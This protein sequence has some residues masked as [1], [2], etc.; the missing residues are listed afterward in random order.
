MD[1]VFSRELRLKNRDVDMFRRLRTSRLF[2]LLQEAAIA[3]TEQLGAGREKTLDR[4]LLWVITLQEARISRLPE[5]GER[6]KL[7]SWPGDMMHVFFPRYSILRGEDGETLLTASA[8]WTLSD[9]ETRKLTFPEETGVTVSGFR[10]GEEPALP[11]APKAL[12]AETT[13]HFTVPRSYTDINGHM[14]N[15]RYFDLLEDTLP[16]DLRDGRLTRIRA[17]YSGEVPEGAELRLTLGRDGRNCTLTG[18]TERRV[19]RLAAD[20]E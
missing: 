17:E 5:Y 10:T 19:F 6:M 14:N 3:H 18:E 11:A 20:F 2:E 4:G 16:E 13:T 9:R 12:P 8:L 1:G 15:A 7:L